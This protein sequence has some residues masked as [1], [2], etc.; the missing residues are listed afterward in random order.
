MCAG[1]SMWFNLQR[2]TGGANNEW[3]IELGRTVLVAKAQN[4]HSLIMT[5][6]SD[7]FDVFS[8]NITMVGQISLQKSQVCRR[9]SDMLL[10][11]CCSLAFVNGSNTPGAGDNTNS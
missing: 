7:P 4:M 2:Q 8:Q 6:A 9:M 5:K 10:H 3:K 1:A 11:Q